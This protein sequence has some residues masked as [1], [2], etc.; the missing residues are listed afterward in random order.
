MLG[1]FINLNKFTK[2][3]LAP[4]TV[5]DI[6]L[7]VNLDWVY[8]GQTLHGPTDGLN[9]IDAL[10]YGMSGRVRLYGT[11]NGFYGSL[12]GYIP[13]SSSR[14]VVS[15]IIDFGNAAMSICGGTSLNNG[16]TEFMR[17]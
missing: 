10:Q 16:C 13:S 14:A 5:I 4:G 8:D 15:G 12:T 6:S 7:N 1:N 2:P 11:P 3:V 17:R 9:L